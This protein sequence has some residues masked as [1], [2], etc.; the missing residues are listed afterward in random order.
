M[1]FFFYGT[2]Q[3]GNPNPAIKDIHERL[4]LLGPGR[5]TG[6]LVAMPDRDGWFPALVP[7]DGDVTGQVFATARDFSVAA[8]A[9]L[10]RYEE[11]D[12]AS[13][14]TSW[15]RREERTLTSGEPVMVYCLN[16][17]PP[18]SAV[19]IPGGDFR[20]WI[21]AQGLPEFSGRGEG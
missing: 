7:G 2:L 11:Y 8:L 14:E 5:I 21:T 16:G 12:P 17:P 15:Y 9:R 3:V 4:V 20:A 6:G 10:D 13:P 19:V 1:R 18:E